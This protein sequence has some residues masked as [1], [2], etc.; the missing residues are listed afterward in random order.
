MPQFSPR[1]RQ[2]GLPLAVASVSLTPV[3]TSADAPSTQPAAPGALTLD[4]HKK[5]SEAI[6]LLGS[7]DFK[8][9]EEAANTV[10]G[11][12]EAAIPALK[13][14]AQSDNPEIARRARSILGNFAFGIRPDTPRTVVEQLN[15]YRRG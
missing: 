4:S 13:E 12:G 15:L 2:W 3:A 7:D 6:D 14:A 1:V 8:T 9:R 10:W 11:F 5:L